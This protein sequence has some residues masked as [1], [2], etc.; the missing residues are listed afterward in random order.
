MIDKVAIQMYQVP[1]CDLDGVMDCS[2]E[3][4]ISFKPL[5]HHKSADG[6]Q[7]SPWHRQDPADV[8]IAEIQRAAPLWE[9]V[10]GSTPQSEHLAWQS[11]ASAGKPVWREAWAKL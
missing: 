2:T 5:S 4:L 11:Q 3:L 7:H 8:H 6:L 10:A 9:S 1:K